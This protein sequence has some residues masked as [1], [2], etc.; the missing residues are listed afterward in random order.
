MARDTSVNVRIT[1]ELR[2][3]LER[4]AAAQKRTLSALVQIVLD[5]YAASHDKPEATKGKRRQ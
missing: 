2:D 1:T 3:K 4:L 5:E